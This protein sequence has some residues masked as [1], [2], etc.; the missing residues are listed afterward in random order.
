M[1]L[2]LLMWLTVV[3]VSASCQ[4]LRV[5]DMTLNLGS[6]QS[7]GR[8]GGLC[9][10]VD[11]ATVSRPEDNLGEV[12]DKIALDSKM[13]ITGRLWALASPDIYLSRYGG[14]VLSTRTAQVCASNPV[15]PGVYEVVLEVTDLRGAVFHFTA[16]VTVRGE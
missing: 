2:K 4:S 3:A 1:Y 16:T 9:I 12:E 15:D 8:P 5:P 6:I 7:A 10:P 13:Q 11:T 14:Y